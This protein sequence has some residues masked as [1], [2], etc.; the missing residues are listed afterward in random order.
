MM[1]A[2]QAMEAVAPTAAH[3]GRSKWR[4]AAAISALVVAAGGFYLWRARQPKSHVPI[5]EAYQLYQQGRSHIQEFT[6]QSFNQSIVDFENAVKLD[7]DYAAAYAGLADAYSYQAVSELKAPGEVMPLA[8]KNAAKAL[9]KDPGMAEAYTSLGVVA[10]MYDWDWPLAEQR[11]RKA[12]A[13]NPRDA[14]TQHFLAHYY[15]TQG[16]WQDALKQM[17]VALDTEKLSPM[18][19]ED[20]SLELFVSRRSNEAARLIG[21]I[22]DRNPQDPFALN[23]QAL[24]LE[25]LGK[26]DESLAAADSAVKL[27]G[28]F[29]DAASL[30]G[31]YCRQG[32]ESGARDILKQLQDAQ[33]QG[34]YVAPMEFAGTYF[35]LGDKDHGMQS[36][37]EAVKE[38]GTNL[39]LGIPDPVFDSVR[40]DPEFAA[41]MNQVHLPPGNWR[42]PPR[43]GK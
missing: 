32:R 12:L 8:E 37:R 18:Y 9:E 14:F 19:G 41:L 33:K 5:P 4:L 6:E 10:L 38:H 13:L 39:A 43:V 25:A 31:V 17:H 23:I 16:S 22:V 28:M 1:A 7:P 35:A 21:P 2:L 40:S 34:R 29:Q 27:P 36:L 42:D 15:E 30:S 20:L 3:P 26:R 24:A 11:F